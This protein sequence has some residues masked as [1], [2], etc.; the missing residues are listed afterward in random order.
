MKL[1]VVEE[2]FMKVLESFDREREGCREI[3]VKIGV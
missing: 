3:K 2:G 1:V